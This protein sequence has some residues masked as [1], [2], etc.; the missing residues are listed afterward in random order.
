[1]LAAAAV[2][3]T[4]LRVAPAAGEAFRV[5]QE[6]VQLGP[7]AGGPVFHRAGLAAQQLDRRL[8][9][10]RVVAQPQIHVAA[11]GLRQRAQAAHQEQAVQRGDLILRQR[12]VAERTGQLARFVQR[13]RRGFV[14]AEARRSAGRHIAGQARVVDVEQQRQ[15]VQHPLLAGGQ[16]LMGALQTARVEGQKTLA[17]QLDAPAVRQGTQV[18]GAGRGAAIVQGHVRIRRRPPP[19]G[20]PVATARAGNQPSAGV[21]MVS[22]AWACSAA[23]R[24]RLVR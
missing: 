16:Q 23:S 2:L 5:D 19:P 6:H 4:Q 14:V 12:P 11:F 15:Q 18:Q 20:D 22:R 3:A 17:Q 9:Q 7:L 1:M 24:P 21:R 8:V 10:R 13:R